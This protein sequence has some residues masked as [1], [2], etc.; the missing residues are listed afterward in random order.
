LTLATLVLGGNDG[1][2]GDL[3]DVE[4]DRSQPNGPRR[5]G[6]DGGGAWMGGVE[7]PDEADE[8][9]PRLRVG[10]S[11]GTGACPPRP[12]DGASVASEDC[13]DS[14]SCAVSSSETSAR[15]SVPSAASSCWYLRGD[16]S[17]LSEP[18]PSFSVSVLFIRSMGSAGSEE[19][20]TVSDVASTKS[21]AS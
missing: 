9:E 3:A 6:K 11:G 18:F 8:T 4:A 13:R 14:V 21:S 12:V 10:S 15:D 2:G 17:R 1:A 5:G 16:F 20:V 7:T 19:G